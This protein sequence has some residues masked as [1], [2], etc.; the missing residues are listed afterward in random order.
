MKSPDRAFPSLEALESRSLPASVAPTSLD[1]SVMAGASTLRNAILAAN[2]DTSADDFTISLRSGT[3]RL[4]QRNTAGQENAAARGDLDVTTTAHKVVIEGQG[5]RGRQATVIDATA[6]RDR[7]FHLLGPGV[8]LE[9]RDLVLRGGRAQDDGTA[10]VGAGETKGQG[11][12]SS[13]REGP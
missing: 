2:A 12:R 1:D 3:Y 7:I 4:T 6:L 5:A 9:L 11:G 8:R 13:T 10:E